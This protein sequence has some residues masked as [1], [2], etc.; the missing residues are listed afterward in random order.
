MCKPP[1]RAS[2][3]SP[4]KRNVGEI[5]EKWSILFLLISMMA[6]CDRDPDADPDL[7]L[8]T[9]LLCEADIDVRL[10]PEHLQANIGHGRGRDYSFQNK[11]INAWFGC[12]PR[13]DLT[14][15]KRIKIRKG[16]MAL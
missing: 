6:C 2:F 5:N 10:Y 16:S 9:A 3:S 11:L 15:S 7:D 8:I 12:V 13:L 4:W 1:A 14:L